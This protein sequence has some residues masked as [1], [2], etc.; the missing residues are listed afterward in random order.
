MPVDP[1]PVFVIEGE[2]RDRFVLDDGAVIAG[3]IARSEEERGEGERSRTRGPQNSSISFAR[4]RGLV[5]KIRRTASS[6]EIF[7][8][9]DRIIARIHCR[10]GSLSVR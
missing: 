5:E 7:T 4:N 8:P 2:G 3:R 9:N 1:E 10:P 6:S